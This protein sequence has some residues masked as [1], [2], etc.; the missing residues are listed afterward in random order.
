[1]LVF[2]FGVKCNV[3]AEQSTVG[4]PETAA[5]R[6][7]NSSVSDIRASALVTAKSPLLVP[8]SDR[9]Q[10]VRKMSEKLV[11]SVDV[12]GSDQLRLVSFVCNEC[13]TLSG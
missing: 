10:V 3:L 1:M 5:A 9:W 8:E 12:C 11:Q 7:N 6:R 2:P 4:I 13:K